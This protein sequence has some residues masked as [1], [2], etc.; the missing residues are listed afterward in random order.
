LRTVT[1]TT[2]EILEKLDSPI[3]K[4]LFREAVSS[5]KVKLCKSCPD[6]K[7]FVAE[8]LGYDEKFIEQYWQKVI[9]PKLV[10]IYNRRDED[11]YTPKHGDK[12]QEVTLVT[13][14]NVLYFTFYEQQANESP[15]IMYELLEPYIVQ[16]LNF[17]SPGDAC[18]AVRHF[19]IPVDAE[20]IDYVLKL[21]RE[22]LDKYPQIRS[23]E[24]LKLLCS[25]SSS[26]PEVATANRKKLKDT[27]YC[28]KEL[29]KIMK[30]DVNNEQ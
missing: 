29:G 5:R 14:A 4:E 15:R 22:V 6:L 13:L 30:G 1:P 3:F 19:F 2:E 26:L 28:R 17:A 23:S 11:S 27:N 12:R 7:Q 10:N 16:C 9:Y 25:I 20:N 8:Q 21:L 24:H 18:K